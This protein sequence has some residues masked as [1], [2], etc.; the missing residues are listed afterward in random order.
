VGAES[1]PGPRRVERS[2]LLPRARCRNISHRV[3]R[4]SMARTLRTAIGVRAGGVAGAAYARTGR[5]PRRCPQG[6]RRRREGPRGVASSSS[7][8]AAKSVP[9]LTTNAKGEW[10]V[11]KIANA[12]E[13]SS[14]TRTRLRPEGVAGVD[15]RR[16]GQGA[17]DR[18]EDDEGRDRTR[19]SPSRL[20]TRKANELLAR[21]A[22]EARAVTGVLVKYPKCTSSTRR[23]PRPTTPEQLREGR[24]APQAVHGERPEQPR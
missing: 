14:S 16:Q 3:M 22:A 15:V 8:V 6:R 17:E 13:R 2:P 1:A 18:H 10:K 21:A 4:K 24:R 11:E 19:A 9:E 5:A 7:Y 12:V 20:A 23:L